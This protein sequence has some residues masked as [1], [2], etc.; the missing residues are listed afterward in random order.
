MRLFALLVVAC[1]G[2]DDEI[3]DL[4]VSDGPALD[5]AGLV[6]A[7]RDG[8]LL[9]YLRHTATTES[10]V[11]D[12]DTIGDCDA[13]RELSDEGREGARIRGG[14]GRTVRCRRR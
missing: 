1:G 13:Q 2:D 11:D 14:A 9:V 10:G 8:G 7:L 5:D 12:Y 3:E 6:D 4:A